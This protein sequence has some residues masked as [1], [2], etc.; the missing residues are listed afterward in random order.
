M[1]S[2]NQVYERLE[3][4]A[5]GGPIKEPR[6][7]WDVLY[8]LPNLPLASQTSVIEQLELIARSL[9]HNAELL[10]VTSTITL[11]DNR[12]KQVL[13]YLIELYLSSPESLRERILQLITFLVNSVG[14]RKSNTES[15][16]KILAKGQ[17]DESGIKAAIRVLQ[18]LVANHT[19]PV[20]YSYFYFSGPG[21]GLE[22]NL[23]HFAEYP[24]QKAISLCFWLRLEEVYTEV[25]AKLFSFHSEGNGG[26]E[27]YFLENKLYYR[28]LGTEYHPPVP[29]SNGILV[30]EFQPETWVFLGLEHERPRFGRN[31]LRAI[32]DG[33]EVLNTPMDYPKFKSQSPS[34]TSGSLCVDFY[35]QVATAM[36][37]EDLI[38]IQKM[39]TIY[40]YYNMA[41]QGHESLRSLDRVIDKNLS[42]KLVMFYHPYRATSSLAYEAARRADAK[43]KGVSGAKQT[44]P[45]RM[46]FLGGVCSF[47]PILELIRQFPDSQT[48]L[49][50]DWLR[51]L[52]VCLRD[53]PDNQLEAS[54]MK[55]FKVLSEMILHF[56]PSTIKEDTVPLLEELY[57]TCSMP[58]LSEQMTVHLL[59][60][61][62][63]WRYTEPSVQAKL[64][65]M[66][67]GLYTRAPKPLS[68]TLGIQEMV[69]ILVHYFKDESQSTG[70]LVSI[71][72]A[73]LLTGGETIASEIT[74]VVSALFG[75]PSV[76][77][78]KHLLILLKKVLSD[79]PADVV[80]APS[81]LFIKHFVNANGV[82][83]LMFLISSSSYETRA[84]CLSCL[85]LV[86]AHPL[87]PSIATH[88]EIF[89]FLCCIIS[90]PKTA[91]R[92]SQLTSPRLS[93]EF[94]TD[95]LS[96][97]NT[98][99][100]LS[101]LVLS[102]IPES[103]VNDED[104]ELDF[105]IKPPPA[106]SSRK[107][108]SFTFPDQEPDI[109]RTGLATHKGQKRG[110][111]FDFD[112]ETELSLPSKTSKGFKGFD[113][114][115]EEKQ[116]AKSLTPQPPRVVKS[117]SQTRKIKPKL[118]GDSLSIDTDKIN[119][120][121]TF[122][123]EK[124][125]IKTEETP[126]EVL[127]KEISEMAQ[128]CVK[129]MKG[130]LVAETDFEIYP[131]PPPS[132]RPQSV[133]GIKQID[134]TRKK[135]LDHPIIEEIS[136]E[137]ASSNKSASPRCE[138]ED[139]VYKAVLE[140]M[141][142][143]SL[144]GADILD[145]SDEIQSTNG[146]RM[147][148]EVVKKGSLELKHKAVQDFL[149]LTKWNSNNAQKLAEDNTWHLWLLDILL[150][151]PKELDSG[152]AVLDIGSRVHT[153]VMKQAMLGN[154]D[155]WKHLRRIQTWY[156][157]NRTSKARE[158]VIG[159][160]EKLLESLQSNA[161]ACRPS[162]NSTLWKNL[163]I[164][165]FLVEELVVY[166]S[167]SQS[168]AGENPILSPQWV[169]SS[170]MDSF[171]QLLDP[172][173]PFSLFE[174]K[175]M[176]LQEEEHLELVR[177]IKK[178]SQAVF[179]T[180]LQMLVF[181]PPAELRNR[182]V[183]I[184]LVTH[185]V[186]ISVKATLDTDN[187]HLWLSITERITKFILLISESAKKQMSS[188]AS[189]AFTSC[190]LYIAR[191]L[192]SLLHTASEDFTHSLLQKCLVTVL[193]CVFS[194]YFHESPSLK[195]SGIKKLISFQNS[196]VTEDIVACIMEQFSNFSIDYLQN[197]FQDNFEELENLVNTDEWQ[198]ALISAGHQVWDQFDNPSRTKAI[199]SNREK[200][201]EKVIKETQQSQKVLEEANARIH[202]KVLKTASEMSDIEDEKRNARVVQ[203]E[204][205]ARQRRHICS[206]RM[207]LLK[208]WSGPWHTDQKFSYEPYRVLDSEKGRPLLKTRSDAYKYFIKSEN[209][210]ISEDP[211]ELLSKVNIMKEKTQ[212]EE[213]TQEDLSSVS[214]AKPDSPLAAV[215]ARESSLIQVE[216]GWVSVLTVRYGLLQIVKSK[217]DTKIRFIYDERSR[218]KFPSHIE[219]FNYVPSPNKPYVKEWSIDKL[220]KVLPKS[221][222][223]RLTAAEF[224]FVDG[225][226]VLFNF[227]D[228]KDRQAFVAQIKKLKKKVVSLQNFDKSKK[229]A[230]VSPEVTQKWEN[231]EISNF[232]YLMHLNHA[233]GRSYHDITQYPVF[234]WV[235]ADYVSK[236]LDVSNHNTY[237][238]LSRNMGS[239][240]PQ[241]R[242]QAFQA[243][244]NST[245]GNEEHPPFHFGSHYSNPGVV[246]YFLLRLFPYSEA[247]KELQDGKF[248][249]ADRLFSGIEDSFRS[250]TTDISD[251]KELIPEFFTLPDFLLNKEKYNFGYTQQGT[252]VD[253]V[254]LPP[255]A[256]NAHEF[257][258]L[259]R[260]ILESDFVS[261]NLHKWIDLIFGYKQTGEEAVKAMNVFYYITYDESIDID[262]VTDPS[263]KSAIEA[264]VVYFGKTPSQLFHK[265]HPQ[266]QS[267]NKINPG[268]TVVSQG[269]QLKIYLPA[270]RKPFS[271]PHNIYNYFDMPEKAI[272]KAKIFKDKEIC[273]V[274]LNG[275]FVRYN[276]WPT[277]MGDNKTPFTCALHK[278]VFLPKEQKGGCIEAK[279]RSLSGFNAPIEILQQGKVVVS[280]AYWDGR[281][282]ISKTAG[283]ETPTDRWHHQST[284]TAIYIDPQDNLGITGAKDGDVILWIIDS[285]YW[286]PRWH[287]IDHYEEVTS[288]TICHQIHSFASC[289]TDGK[290]N[291]YS[292]RKGRLLRVISLP[293]NAPAT[294][295]TFSPATPAK[296]IL[297]SP[298][299]N[300]LYSFSVNGDNLHRSH[301]RCFFVTSPVV[302]R[303]LE[304]VEYLVYGTEVGDIVVRSTGNLEVLHRY[305]L[306]SGTPVLSV[307]VTS[308]LRFLLAGGAD[309]EL[310]VLTDPE[311]TLSLLEKQWQVGSM[312]NIGGLM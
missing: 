146:L 291:I 306:A 182:G 13:N 76:H 6:I 250:A 118:F 69:E 303:D 41:P 83:L 17:L 30:Y 4:M 105:G 101:N 189:K 256:P 133:K 56:N 66:L 59:W 129:Y 184:K 85:D 273:A 37:F 106:P 99:Q 115:E 131:M 188:Q 89:D 179:K 159:L 208:K 174:S 72:E 87:K 44:L 123:G 177:A 71:M 43:F 130:S 259:N 194:V 15:V 92:S 38:T 176:S 165:T 201:A 212:E 144:E 1:E 132:F 276:W 73:V 216:I 229:K 266:K 162:L 23:S 20:P 104:N 148:E 75:K 230:L 213:D 141:L 102:D 301:E 50:H 168:E 227:P 93:S 40:G 143:R 21:S 236:V 142:K 264:Q 274:R 3:K 150:V 111:S 154:E 27:A 186:C 97:E 53:R 222:V 248:D 78:Q 84:V 198:F 22:I 183:F 251:V 163:L 33:E 139:G 57:Y 278:E 120:N 217:S 242:T 122:G 211:T 164:T 221:Y 96:L 234:P 11:P 294:M 153:I 178:Q 225:R 156:E 134:F 86:L 232:E 228:F 311:A 157:A 308:D 77:I 81:H 253:D 166:T 271:K 281:I 203:A 218:S 19:R 181:E 82:E 219:L 277:P 196:T 48:E 2:E 12:K 114:E 47:L 288:V 10:A 257:V 136:L 14:V 51:L 199:C 209:L 238:D 151:V 52:I 195:D 29:G 46:N 299:E 145:D 304:C 161:M 267:K 65:S 312:F 108:I 70:I 31:Q 79:R 64:F 290:C 103:P 8:S 147:V 80:G 34:F 171:F 7:V 187:V 265:P 100:K 307:V 88:Q 180:D 42:K 233:A 298:Q 269:A 247:A 191:F 210:P 9:L 61:M 58:Q 272:L 249:I 254:E 245:R 137:M 202:A 285:E 55:L 192:T 300:F 26:I 284:I 270:R 231:W 128:D 112:E 175:S 25:P 185:L 107:K 200:L 135:S 283:K 24:F 204:E 74:H 226:T 158:L 287:Y 292:L 296:V 286:Q 95:R 28:T 91:R 160:L 207:Q 268:P 49:F 239:I 16:F 289:S 282:R 90:P 237:R 305:S 54:K 155:G 117:F 275:S 63:L 279:D 169:D 240:G 244:F 39:K 125:E 170:L 94:N 172:I 18:V 32:V 261:A 140:M 45:S 214:L 223:T 310:T 36:V 110:F 35:G 262:K 5:Q 224:F 243:R 109:S 255:W 246:L 205:K 258:R 173:W 127:L 293:D 124:G 62:E 197:L 206:K 60:F 309:G 121:Y 235:I 263:L 193:K 295:V 113:F 297:F 241:E 138:E 116:D 126:D 220:E 252:K 260:E 152:L 302:V 98:S 149:M 280:G 215:F 68:K 119:E 67:K 167:N 190:V